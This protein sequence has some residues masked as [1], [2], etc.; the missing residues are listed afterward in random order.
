MEAKKSRE[1]P[2]TVLIQVSNVKE[3]FKIIFINDR[4]V[5]LFVFLCF[6]K[7]I[8][9]TFLKKVFVN[10]GEHFI[11]SFEK[12]FQTLFAL[13]RKAD[14]PNMRSK[15]TIN[16][17]RMYKNSKPIR[18]AK[19]KIIKAAPFQS[20][21]ASGTVAR[22]EPHRKWFGNTR[23]LG[24]EQLQKFQEHMDKVV[25]DPFQVVLQ[26]TRLPITL[27]QEKAKV[28]IFENILRS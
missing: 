8:W 3:L 13:E 19:G 27:L 20:W 24:Q 5:N 22:V 16:R 17:L 6:Y 11:L 2:V 4:V 25:K 7:K 9:L 1:S 26:Q 23:V 18:N 21:H 28:M 14:G 12:F 15:A 10:L